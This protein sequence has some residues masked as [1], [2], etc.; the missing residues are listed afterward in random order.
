MVNVEQIVIT[1]SIINTIIIFA[2][3]SI[4]AI[5]SLRQRDLLPWLSLFIAV[6]IGNIFYI[7][8]FVDSIYQL[9]A[10]LFFGISMFCVL[11]STLIEYHKLFIKTNSQKSLTIRSVTTA[12]V[13]SPLIIGVQIFMICILLTT[14]MMLFRIYFK[15]RSPTRL[16]LIISAFA[17]VISLS[18]QSLPF[19][20]VEYSMVIGNA[21]EIFFM[22]MLFASG[23]VALI[24]QKLEESHKKLMNIITS[25]SDTSVNVANIATE[26]AASASEVNASSEEISSTVQNMSNDAQSIMESTNNLRNVMALIKNIADQTNLLALNASIEAGRAGEHGRGFAVVADEVRKL[27]EE[28]KLS[29]TDTSQKI[30]VIINKIKLSTASME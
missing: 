27:A 30:D 26:L 19:F 10:Y 2:G 22:S 29:V 9:L 20:E 8:Q 12:I 7:F 5:A 25:A 6:E 16:L 15:T 1:I 3:G 4:F 28:S 23:V 13:L 18:F 24:E 11:I 21:L 17:A 14:M